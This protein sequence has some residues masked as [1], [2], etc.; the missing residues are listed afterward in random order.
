[1]FLIIS[2]SFATELLIYR[3]QFSTHN[4]STTPYICNNAGN[5]TI[6]EMCNWIEYCNGTTGKYAQ[7]R[8]DNGH[9]DPMN[10]NIWSIGNENYIKQEIGYKPIEEWA[11]FVTNAAKAMRKVDPTVQIAAATSNTR[12]LTGSCIFPSWHH[13]LL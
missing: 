8:K 12:E 5:G 4:F 2:P 10:V 9:L 11:P 13:I 6:E 7:M 3:S 1:M